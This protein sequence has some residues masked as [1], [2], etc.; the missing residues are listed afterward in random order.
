MTPSRSAS[1]PPGR[2]RPRRSRRF[3]R[4]ATS[5]SST[6]TNTVAAGNLTPYG[7]S[8]L[9]QLFTSRGSD[10]NTVNSVIG[11]TA[12]DGKSADVSD[13]FTSTD[14]FSLDYG[15]LVPTLSALGT[16]MNLYAQ[17]GNTSQVGNA[18]LYTAGLV[19]MLAD[20]TLKT[21]AATS[22]VPLPAALWLLGSGLVGLAG[23]GRRRAVAVA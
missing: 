23:V 10:Y 15:Q 6:S 2:V 22:P 20:G 14:P 18:Q 5:I 8:S 17:T 19:T 11:G 1:W 21:V 9:Q 12:G 16:S 7:T 13:H 4:A 3:S